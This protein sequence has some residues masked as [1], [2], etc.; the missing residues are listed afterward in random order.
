MVAGKVAGK[1]PV[2]GKQ[3][4]P[5]K[6]I[7]GCLGCSGLLLISFVI[8]ALV[9]VSQTSATGQ[10]PLATS[11]GIDTGSFTNTL[12]LLV[13]LIFGFIVVGFLMLSAVGVFRMA[14]ARKEDKVTKKKGLTLAAISAGLLIVFAIT[15]VGL[16]MYL[17]S[18]EV[19]VDEIPAAG[20]VSVPD[21]TLNQTA[22]FEVQFDASRVPIN[23]RQY[24]IVSYM[25]DFGDGG[26]STVIAPVHTFTDKGRFDVILRIEAVD[27]QS[28]EE[29]SETFKKIVSIANVELTA[30]FDAT[31][32]SGPAPLTVDFDASNSVAPAGQITDYEW[33]FDDNNTF[34]DA[35]GVTTSNEFAQVGTY[36]VNLRIT[37]NT[38][39]FAV[40]SKEIEVSGENV[41]VAVID[42]PTADGRFFVGSQ[43]TFKAEES[44]SPNGKIEK[45]E[46]DFGDGSSKATTRTA[47]HK[48]EEEGTYDVILVVTD[49]E[50]E[51]GEA[52]ETIKVEMPEA[53][54]IAV[55]KTVPAPADDND[56][57]EGNAPMEVAF[58]GSGS[59]DA[60]DNIVE[61]NWDFDGDG[62]TD[63]SGEN[64]TYAYNEEGTY[65]ATLTVV[66]AEDNE[67][68]DIIV[69]KVGAQPIQA[70][71]VADPIEGTVP[72][73]VNF[74]SSSSSYPGGQIVSYEWDFG[75]GSPKRIDTSSVSYRYDKIGTFDAAVT[76][77]AS[78]NSRSTASV[79][80]NIRPVSVKACFEPTTTQGEA[81]LSIEFNPSCAT[82]TIIKYSWD[83]GDGESSVKRKPTHTFE[84]PG[85]YKVVLEVSDNQNVIDTFSQDILVTGSI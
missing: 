7:I 70:R 9:F 78:D 46:W 71:I 26:S 19:A 50:S 6:V 42:I 61:Y 53:A 51:T 30:V 34:T 24:D 58:D 79:P 39:Q 43:Y 65:N 13:N 5:K 15:W 59:Q 52:T 10:N 47:N 69:V 56:Y 75:D 21:E 28:G 54:P 44:S 64:V 36:T 8:F 11:L 55:I 84:N 45:Y 81:P 35:S 48:Y 12:I 23:T 2:K 3:P 85:S 82:G 22:P 4:N 1:P 37:D 62:S 40:T 32:M 14:M 72:L 57:L 31:P 80:V 41:P 74:D 67:S 76:A 38:G 49:E 77:I 20:I 16:Y 17:S 18:K 25:W 27:K 66:D 68:S 60:D 63:S 29:A 73:T 33:D 83:F